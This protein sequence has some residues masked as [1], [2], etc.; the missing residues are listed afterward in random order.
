[1]SRIEHVLINKKKAF[2]FEAGQRFVVKVAKSIVASIQINQTKSNPDALY[3]IV[4]SNYGKSY[5]DT[6]NVLQHFYGMAIY[7]VVEVEEPVFGIIKTVLDKTVDRYIVWSPS[8]RQPSQQI[9]T[10]AKQARYVAYRMSEQNK[11]HVFYWSKLEGNA[12]C[13]ELPPE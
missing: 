6:T 2:T 12:Q 11:G 9:F 8:S 13:V 7:Q 4:S 3:A 1:M 10:S 5:K